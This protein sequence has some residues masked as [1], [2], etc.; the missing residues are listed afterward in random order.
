ML[1]HYMHFQTLVDLYAFDVYFTTHAAN[2]QI[3]ICG[4]KIFKNYSM[5]QYNR[6]IYVIF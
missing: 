2:K 4:C 3:P 6:C 1:H 5:N